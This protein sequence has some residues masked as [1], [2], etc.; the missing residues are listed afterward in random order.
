MLRAG[1]SQARLSLFSR[2]VN[3]IFNLWEYDLETK[4]TVQLTSGPGPDLWPMRDPS[5][6]G[7]FFING[8]ESGFLSVYQLQSKST[9]DIV[10]ELATQPTL[11][12][13]AKR[14]MYITHARTAEY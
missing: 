6:N 5:G 8:R 12:R 11:S 10:S 7:I 1:E 14:V 2:E 3:G 9:T 4:T 13:D